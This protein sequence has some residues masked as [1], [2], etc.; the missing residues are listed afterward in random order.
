MKVRMLY[1]NNEKGDERQNRVNYM[2]VK[3]YGLNKSNHMKSEK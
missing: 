1:E 3:M 2:V